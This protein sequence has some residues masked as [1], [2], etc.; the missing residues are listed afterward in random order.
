MSGNLVLEVTDLHAG[1]AGVDILRGVN[2]KIQAGEVHA[3]MG[4]NGSGKSTLAYTLAGHPNYNVSA[5]KILFHGQNLLDMAAEERARNGLFLSFQHPMEI[6]GVRL[7]HFLRASLNA[8]LR[9]RGVAEMDPLKFDRWLTLKAKILEIDSSLTKRS[10]NEGFSGGERKRNEIL[11]M[12]ILEPTLSILDETDSGLDVDALRTVAQGINKL[13]RPE[14]A[15]VLVTHYHRIL[16]YVIPDVVHILMDGK[17]V[18][19]GEKELA[20]QIE[21]YGYDWLESPTEKK[22]HGSAKPES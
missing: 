13:R 18:K 6:P 7:D 1:V 17:I 20:M 15:T 14:S 3:I 21:E 8:I 2:L 10:V 16:S 22:V 9:K 19:S 4:P 12:A 5:G 11:Q